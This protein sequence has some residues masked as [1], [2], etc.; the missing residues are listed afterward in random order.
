MNL[1]VDSSVWVAA[2]DTR[3]SMNA[4]AIRILQSAD[5]L[6]LSDH[7]L[8]EVWF[9]LRRRV[10]TQAAD[11]FWATAASSAAELVAVAPA[12]L[13]HA[14]EIRQVFADQPFSV[15]DCTSF[16][17]ME[18]LGIQDAASFDEHFRIYRY[19]PNRRRAFRIHD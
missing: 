3:D 8:L 19:G 13:A 5:R 10:S 15:A 1:F 9:L 7:I 11:A 6:F 14:W 16:A 12:D 2:A 17:L 4:D 18:R